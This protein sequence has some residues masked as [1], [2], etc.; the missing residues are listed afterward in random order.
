MTFEFGIKMVL[1]GLANAEVSDEGP[2]LWYVEHS[3]NDLR[4]E[5]RNP[6][7]S[8]HFGARGKPKCLHRGND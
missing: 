3:T 2:C 8:Q 5:D 6:A 1:C 7:N 4:L